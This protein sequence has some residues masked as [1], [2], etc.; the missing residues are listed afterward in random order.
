MRT[1]LDAIRSRD[2][3]R[4]QIIATG[5]HLD[6][7]HGRTVDD[8]RAAG[9][10]VDAE[11][12]WPD[13]TD[14]FGYAGAVGTAA[15]SLAS[16]YA[17]LKP[18]VVLVVGD[19]VE[20]FAAAFSAHLANLLVA[21]VHG[22]DRAIGQADDALRHAISKLTHLHFPATAKSRERL[23]K[24]GEDEWRLFLVGAPGID[25]IEQAASSPE[26][27]R[28]RYGAMD[29]GTALVVLHP[30]RD[31]AQ[32]E[33]ESADRLLRAVRSAGVRRTVIVGSN[34]D[35]GRDGIARRWAEAAGDTDVQLHANV[36]RADFLGLMRDAALLVGNSS[37][38]IIEAASF[39]LPT[40]DIGPR[41]QGRERS[42]NVINVPDDLDAITAAVRRIWN[43]GQPLRPPV[44]NVYGTNGAG[45]RIAD[46]LA[47]YDPATIS[48]RKLIAY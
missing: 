29:D 1:T 41:Q 4:L 23:S 42:E 10:T 28:E 19:R 17:Q 22:G 14:A 3:L 43:D 26:H 48:Q 5:S 8:I 12:Q 18:D 37:S 40:I 15:A 33:Y 47:T 34:N 46:H 25:G 24:M 2:E 35:P 31:D 30:T 9:Y 39:N 38:G 36:R 6:P 27:I 20:A 16:A 7:V 32:S 11:V 45:R 21:Q 44:E 13:S